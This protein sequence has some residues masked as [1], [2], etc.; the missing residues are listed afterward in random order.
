VNEHLPHNKLFHIWNINTGY[1]K[2]HLYLEAT[3]TGVTGH[4][5]KEIFGIILI[6]KNLKVSK[7]CL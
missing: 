1:P 5:N 6:K 4:P 2:R 3:P 7:S